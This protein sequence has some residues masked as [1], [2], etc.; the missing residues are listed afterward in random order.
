MTRHTR[1]D[2]SKTISDSVRRRLDELDAQD[3][4]DLGVLAADA[5]SGDSSG[6]EAGFVPDVLGAVGGLSRRGGASRP[7][8]TPDL[9]DRGSS[10]LPGSSGSGGTCTPNSFVPGTEVVLADGSRKAIEEVELGDR[11]LATDP[12]TGETAAKRVT[13][14][15]T[16]E[17]EKHLVEVT[18]DV[19]GDRGDATESVTATG[20]HPFW[21]PD[22]DEWVQAQDLQ[23]G[24]RVRTAEGEQRLVT[25]IRTWTA[26][27]RVHN[28]TVDDTHTYYVALDGQDE[29]L[30]H[31]SNTQCWDDGGWVQ[32]GELDDQ[33][34]AT[35]MTAKVTKSMIN[36]GSRARKTPVG[37]VSGKSPY[38]H[39]RGHLLA[40]VLGGS[41]KDLRNLTTIYHDPV[42]FPRM[43]DQER[44]VIRAVERGDG[45]VRYNVTPKYSG[46]NNLPDSIRMEAW[47]VYGSKFVD[48]DLINAR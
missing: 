29:S 47:D 42:N 10:P 2:P 32:Y 25:S 12:E 33:G 20:E 22:R 45:P 7:G 37:F 9:P 46:R 31:N 16:G 8:S 24:D 41:G 48:S 43:F 35:G 13:A 28:L 11:V 23:V 19:D 40:K 26:L 18:V 38:G 27:Q 17:G 4:V 34:R 5:A 3:P 15:I 1:P 44:K 6:E 36:T 39:A 30:V 14:T 21:V